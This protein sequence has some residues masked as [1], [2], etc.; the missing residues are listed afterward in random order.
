MEYNALNSMLPMGLVD[1]DG[2]SLAFVQ[3]RTFEDFVYARE[4]HEAVSELFVRPTD[5]EVTTAFRVVHEALHALLSDEEATAF[6]RSAT[7]GSNP[8]YRFLREK[9]AKPRNTPQ[10]I[11]KAKK[12]NAALDVLEGRKKP[13]PG[14]HAVFIQPNE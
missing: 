13:R 6:K 7:R 4:L 8:E 14:L 12:V 10:S 3:A 5:E 9:Y 11:A 1:R 2:R